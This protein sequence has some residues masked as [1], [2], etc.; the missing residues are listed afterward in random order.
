M[1]RGS[2]AKCAE[3]QKPQASAIEAG[4]EEQGLPNGA[5]APRAWATVNKESGWGRKE[6]W[7]SRTC[8]S[9]HKKPIQAGFGQTCCRFPRG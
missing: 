3:K 5:A 7:R 8:F 9:R 4:Y 2:R 1:P 6:Q